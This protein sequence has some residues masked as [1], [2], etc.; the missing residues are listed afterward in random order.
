MTDRSRRT[1]TLELEMPDDDHV[2]GRL[3][4]GHGNSTEFVG[5][6]GLAGAIEALS[7]DASDRVEVAHG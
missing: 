1:L 5:W 3:A 4:D 7:A 2:A 6:L